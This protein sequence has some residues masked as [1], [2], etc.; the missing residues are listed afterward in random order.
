MYGKIF[1][2]LF[3]GSMVGSGALTFAVWGYVIATMKLD[4]AVGAQ[5]ELNPILLAAILGED[6]GD[7]EKVI[8][9]LC[10]PDPKS[11]TPTEEGRRLVRLGQFVYRVVNGEKYTRIRNEEERREQVR[12][13][14]ERHR[15]KKKSDTAPAEGLTESQKRIIERSRR[16]IARLEAIEAEVR[17]R[18]NPAYAKDQ[19]STVDLQ[20]G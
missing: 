13:A 10:S 5:V 6:S 9:K 17:S 2:S 19:I 8:E 1:E 7:I 20:V 4:R 11:S 18:H 14:V 3:K 12:A 16:K 15:E